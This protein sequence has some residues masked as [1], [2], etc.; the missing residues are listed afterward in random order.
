MVVLKTHTSMENLCKS[1]A[2]LGI[3]IMLFKEIFL[4][5]SNNLLD[6]ARNEGR[7][8]IIQNNQNGI[9]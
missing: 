1:V 5:S 3:K 7:E 8:L 2:I 9:I 4:L 6:S